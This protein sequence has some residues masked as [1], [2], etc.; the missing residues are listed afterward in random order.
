M[1]TSIYLSNNLLSF[2]RSIHRVLLSFWMYVLCEQIKE[3]L[4]F[5]FTY[6]AVSI[7]LASGM[8]LPLLGSTFMLSPSVAG[9]MMGL[10][11]VSVVGN[12]LLLRMRYRERQ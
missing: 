1:L 5:S 3:N 6:N 10:S 2:A 4:F 7:P 12:S 11:S 9:L 8:M